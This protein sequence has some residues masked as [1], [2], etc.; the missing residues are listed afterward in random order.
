VYYAL[1]LPSLTLGV[2]PQIFYTACHPHTIL[3][4]LHDVLFAIFL[5]YWSISVF[6]S[7]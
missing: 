6:L 7:I 1:G 3:L 2:V 4:V 5:Y